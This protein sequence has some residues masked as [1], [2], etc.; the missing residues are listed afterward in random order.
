MRFIRFLLVMLIEA[1]IIY[2]SLGIAN[3]GE[4]VIAAVSAAVFFFA[5]SFFNWNAFSIPPETGRGES[6]A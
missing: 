2:L 1:G 5:G 6:H 4:S 3:N